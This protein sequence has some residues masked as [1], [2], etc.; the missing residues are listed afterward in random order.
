MKLPR[1]IALTTSILLAHH[2]R[3]T[4]VSGTISTDTTW[5][6]AGSPY[7][8]TGSITVTGGATLTIEPGV[9][10]RFGSGRRLSI[11]SATSAGAL[12][13]AG[14]VGQK[15]LFTTNTEPPAPGQWSD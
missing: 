5:T 6:L 2:A 12:V 7:I 3:A 8:V 1:L 13:A 10:V 4:N 15:V 9:T 11:G 14:T